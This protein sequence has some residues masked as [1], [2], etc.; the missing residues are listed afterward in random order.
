[1]ARQTKI[2]CKGGWKELN[3]PSPIKETAGNG[4]G[5]LVSNSWIQRGGVGEARSGGFYICK[6]GTVKE[7][8][9]WAD[10]RVAFNSRKGGEDG[11]EGRSLRFHHDATPKAEK[12][13]EGERV[14]D[15][16]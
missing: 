12:V 13:M 2:I 10:N 7:W 1:V 5:G 4:S 9:T 14:K 8:G 3:I 11:G 6:K 16:C 15:H